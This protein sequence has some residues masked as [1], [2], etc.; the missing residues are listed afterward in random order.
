MWLLLSTFVVGTRSEAAA[1]GRG[2]GPM[3]GGLRRGGEELRGGVGRGGGSMVLFAGFD[4][5]VLRRGGGGMA[6]VVIVGIDGAVGW[7]G[8]MIVGGAGIDPLLIFPLGAFAGGSSL[9][10]CSTAFSSLLCCSVI[11][12]FSRKSLSLCR[13]IKE[14]KRQ[15]ARKVPAPAAI[16]PILLQSRA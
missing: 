9:R 12:V 14:Y 4:G 16:Q 11:T 10:T 1:D 5:D 13:V 6:C 8:A 3:L 15:A 2:G 7:S